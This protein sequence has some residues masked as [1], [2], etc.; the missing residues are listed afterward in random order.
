MNDKKGE[1]LNYIKKARKSGLSDN[2]IFNYLKESGWPEKEINQNLKKKNYKKIL[3]FSRKNFFIFFFCLLFLAFGLYYIYSTNLNLNLE[4]EREFSRQ[5]DIILRT[6]FRFYNLKGELNLLTRVRDREDASWLEKE[7]FLIDKSRAANIRIDDLEPGKKYDLKLLFNSQIGNFE[8][9]IITFET[10]PA[11]IVEE[12]RFV[13]VNNGTAEFEIDIN[14]NTHSQGFVY[15]GSRKK[16]ETEWKWAG[17]PGE[18]ATIDSSGVMQQEIE[19]LEQ[20][21]EYEFNVNLMGENLEIT[22]TRTRSFVIQ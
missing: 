20:G 3:I 21:E 7:S 4:V 11:P 16:G 1:L 19:D 8:S 10:L 14:L 15:F 6:D 13:E 5:V 22:T 9:D 17:K 18:P 12:L 2:K